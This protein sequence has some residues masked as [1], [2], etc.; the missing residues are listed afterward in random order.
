MR[1]I[2][3][4]AQSVEKLKQFAKKLKRKNGIPHAEALNKAAKQHNYNHWGHVTW[5]AKETLRLENSL[6]EEQFSPEIRQIFLGEGAE[7]I[8]DELVEE[9]VKSGMPRE[10]VDEARALGFTYSRTRKSFLGPVMTDEDF[11]ED[12]DT[13]DE[14]IRPVSGKDAFI[15][16][17][18]GFKVKQSMAEANE[19][20][21]YAL[22][23]KMA[24]GTTN[25]ADIAR[26]DHLRGV[27][28]ED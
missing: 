18:G 22:L 1:F 26:L 4:S 21:K 3:T 8:T 6:P 12:D 20:E 25:L 13:E 24:K 15:E 19:R 23:A 2:V 16:A 11:P 27:D 9:L 5:C 28:D 10:R 17:T 14:D 7:E